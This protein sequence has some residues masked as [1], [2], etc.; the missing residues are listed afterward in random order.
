M[1][2]LTKQGVRDLN[3]LKGSSK[4]IRLPEPP[5]QARQAPHC[6]HIHTVERPSSGSV[7][8]LFCQDCQRYL[9]DDDL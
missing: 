8:Y 9:G 1:A 5:R 4:G 3:D 7:P 2:K 6:F